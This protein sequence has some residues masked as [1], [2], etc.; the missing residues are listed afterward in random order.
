M[1]KLE[2]RKQ[3]SQGGERGGQRLLHALPIFLFLVPVLLD[4]PGFSLPVFSRPVSGL[5]LSAP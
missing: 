4:A 3:K 5:R 1:L 2:S